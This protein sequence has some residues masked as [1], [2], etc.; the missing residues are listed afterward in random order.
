MKSKSNRYLIIALL[1]IIYLLAIATFFEDSTRENFWITLSVAIASSILA[2]LIAWFFD[3]V[4]QNFT[5]LKLWLQTKTIH[6]R[7]KIRFSMSYVYRIRVNDKFLLVKNSKWDFYQPVGGVYKILP[8]ELAQ[9]QERFNLDLDKKLPTDGIMKDDLRVMV[10]ATKAIEFL[11]WFESG[12]NR[13]ISHWRE[14][15]EELLRTN[16]LKFDDFPHINYRY[17]GTVRT[18]LKR[19]K[20]LNCLEILRYDVYDL[21]PDSH[22]QKKLVELLYQGD[23]DYVKWADE[24][25]INSLGFD[26]RTRGEEYSIGEHTKWTVNLKYEK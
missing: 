14:F 4:I 20:K 21:L 19:S 13:E 10:P 17:V 2:P 7:R 23:T 26:E 11:D 22:Q 24:I 1:I 6:R 18:P 3:G 16:V 9:L 12:K 15:S 25:I 5:W 8:G